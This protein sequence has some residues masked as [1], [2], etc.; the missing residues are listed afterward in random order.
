MRKA[1]FIMMALV[2]LLTSMIPA[3][4]SAS[5]F[6]TDSILALVNRSNK[7]SK[8]Y[9]PDDL[10]T[11]HV[12]A[13]KKSQEDKIDMRSEA[14]SALEKLFTAAFYEQGYVLLAV[15]GYRSFGIQQ[16]LFS[17]KTEEMGSAERAGRTVAPAGASEHQLGLAMDLVSKTSKELNRRF[18]ST[19]E[20]QWVDTNAHRFGFIVRYKTEWYSIT[21][22]AG[23][24]WHIRYV[25]LA[26]ATAI[27]ELNIPLETYIETMRQLPEFVLSRG[28]PY[29]LKGLYSLLSAG[30]L[31]ILEGLSAVTPEEENTILK[32]LSARFLPADVTYEQA[33]WAIYP[34]PMPTSAPY[35]DAD[36]E[37]ATLDAFYRSN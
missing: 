19:P 34:T 27:H 4:C 23:E 12:A 7:L 8:N 15:S 28:T 18:G 1:A 30:D 33:L 26:H 13:G 32:N 20:G 6:D 21:T 37:E 31:Q 17:Q 25:G 11:P 14:A 35:R 2:M 24:P 36:T 5:V 3:N 29:L 22:Y 10:V 16:V 9:A